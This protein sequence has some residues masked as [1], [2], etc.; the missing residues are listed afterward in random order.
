MAELI[1]III[2][3]GSLLGMGV[4]LYRRIPQISEL[5]EIPVRF[6]LKEN[7]FKLGEKIKNISFFKSF[8]AEIL[9]QKILSKIRILILRTDNKTFSWLQKLREKMKKKKLD[10]DNYWQKLK[11]SINQKGRKEKNLPA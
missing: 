10:E 11:N 5:P 8:S 6:C 1:A 9:L 2:L 7:F 4:I 3:F